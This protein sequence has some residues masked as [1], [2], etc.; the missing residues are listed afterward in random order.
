M[1]DSF[2]QQ[3][4][5]FFIIVANTGVKW[6]PGMISARDMANYEAGEHLNTYMFSEQAVT[7]VPQMVKNSSFACHELSKPLGTLQMY[8]KG[9]I[10][11][12]I[13]RSPAEKNTLDCN[14]RYKPF[15]DFTREHMMDMLQ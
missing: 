7:N 11:P 4:L 6:Y 12:Y 10:L 15:H 9:H 13:S 1:Q 8:W 2:Q 14:K 5:L 3:S